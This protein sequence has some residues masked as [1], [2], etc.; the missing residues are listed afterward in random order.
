MTLFYNPKTRKPHPWVIL[1]FI[2]IPILLVVLLFLIVKPTA[3]KT[4][5]ANQTPERDIFSQ[6]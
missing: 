6:K 3:D 5:K 4:G 2:L 1:I